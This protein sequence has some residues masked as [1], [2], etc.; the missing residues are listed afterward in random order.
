[1]PFQQGLAGTEFG[2]NVVFEHR[3]P[4]GHESACANGACE[5]LRQLFSTHVPVGREGT[6]R[7]GV[8]LRGKKGIQPLEAYDNRAYRPDHS[9][10]QKRRESVFSMQRASVRKQGKAE[11]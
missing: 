2:K 7:M 3:A 4:E 6:A 10:D 8:Q 5:G 9:R 1:M 11:T